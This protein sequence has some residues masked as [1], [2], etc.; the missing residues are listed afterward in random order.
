MRRWTVL[1][2]WCAVIIIYSRSANMALNRNAQK[3]FYRR[4][5]RD[6]IGAMMDVD[7]GGP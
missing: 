2:N 6:T 3:A 7:G 5:S 4:K 1:Q